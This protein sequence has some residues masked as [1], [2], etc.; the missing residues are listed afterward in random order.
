[1]NGRDFSPRFSCPLC[2][3]SS[4][5][6]FSSCLT[7]ALSL[8][9]HYFFC[10]APLP[11]CPLPPSLAI[12]SSYFLSF[13]LPISLRCPF[14]AA[15]LASFTTS[16]RPLR[17]PCPPALASGWS[18]PHP[19]PPFHS[20]S[21]KDKKDEHADCPQAHPKLASQGPKSS[22]TGPASAR[23]LSY[24]PPLQHPSCLQR[25]TR[26]HSGG[27]GCT[28]FFS[29]SPLFVHLSEITVALLCF[30]SLSFCSDAE[31]IHVQRPFLSASLPMLFSWNCH[32]SLQSM[33]IA[34]A[35]HLLFHSKYVVIT[36]CCN[37]IHWTAWSQCNY[38][39][40]LHSLL[41]DPYDD[42]RRT[43]YKHVQTR[44]RVFSVVQIQCV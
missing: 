13:L 4:L 35:Q 3:L 20:L 14:P 19:R 23:S 21:A 43:T 10:L 36:P 25:C 42:A 1:M 28:S 7:I 41:A 37:G 26:L 12:F 11:P 33:H 31:Y 34:G 17:D 30:V 18:G 6:S 15:H 8:F 38:D 5:L 39:V 9:S 22:H 24:T 29:V 16:P 27:A 2:L 40:L 44:R 32:L